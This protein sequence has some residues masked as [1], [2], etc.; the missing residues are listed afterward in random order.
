MS[1]ILTY[2]CRQRRRK[3]KAARPA[4]QKQWCLTAQH[5]S[6][7]QPD[8]T[9]RVPSARQ[10]AAMNTL[11]NRRPGRHCTNPQQASLSLPLNQQQQQQQQTAHQAL[12]ESIHARHQGASPML[13]QPQKVISQEHLR[14]SRKRAEP[15]ESGGPASN[16]RVSGRKVT[17]HTSS[18]QDAMDDD[19]ILGLVHQQAEALRSSARAVLRSLDWADSQLTCSALHAAASPSAG[20][21]SSASNRHSTAGAG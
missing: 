1:T 21:P 2:T 12:L 18:A 5:D 14:K 13:L 16:R 19:Y 10:A 20:T 15:S 6:L 17:L 4:Q 9:T 8:T 7:P 3:T 11:N